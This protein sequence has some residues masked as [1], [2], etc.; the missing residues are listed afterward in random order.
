M[1][2]F[3]SFLLTVRVNLLRENLS[4][5]LDALIHQLTHRAK[6]RIFFQKS[7]LVGAALVTFAPQFPQQSSQIAPQQM[8]NPAYHFQRLVA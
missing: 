8:L 7:R 2:C 6:N 3:V 5:P 4:K 1:L